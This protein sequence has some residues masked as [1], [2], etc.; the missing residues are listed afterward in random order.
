ME[1]I[2]L[3]AGVRTA[4]KTLKVRLE[5]FLRTDCHNLKSGGGIGHLIPDVT[6][7]LHPSLGLSIKK[8]KTRLLGGSEFYYQHLFPTE[9]NLSVIGR[10]MPVE[11]T[12]FI[13]T[14]R[15]I[16]QIAD[17][18]KRAH[19]KSGKTG[20]FEFKSTIVDRR[21][22]FFFEEDF[23]ILDIML[24]INF[25]ALWFD[26]ALR[27]EL[28]IL[29]VDYDDIVNPDQTKVNHCLSSFL[30]DNVTLVGRLVSA[31]GENP[32]TISER[33]KNQ[34]IEYAGK[35]DVNFDRIGL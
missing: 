33:A 13:V 24:V 29:F 4:S 6:P 2:F 1:H 34:I 27:S 5:H 9:Y 7:H 25:Y 28:D 15:N 21:R 16:F 26:L 30:D 3:A 35:F 18:L 22:E 10:I 31:F 17:S 12:K 11:K 19:K 23:N 32:E 20:F 8:L 14:T